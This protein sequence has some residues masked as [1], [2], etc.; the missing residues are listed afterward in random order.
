M[1]HDNSEHLRFDSRLATRRDWLSAKD[2]Q[3]VLDA[4]PDLTDKAE[5]LEE[6]EGQASSEEPGALEE[7]AAPTPESEP[8]STPEGF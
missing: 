5:F 3:T 1:A 6:E 2:R 8:Q 4:L 7:A